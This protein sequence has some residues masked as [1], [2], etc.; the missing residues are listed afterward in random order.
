MG[1]LWPRQWS[2]LIFVTQSGAPIDPS[3]TRKLVQRVAVD[4]GVADEGRGGSTL[5]PYDLRHSATSLL[6]AAGVPPERLADLLGHRDTRM[7]F[8]HY[9]H[10]VTPTI[11]VAVTTW[12]R[13]WAAD[14][15]GQG[16]VREPMREPIGSRSPDSGTPCDD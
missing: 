5:S 16:P 13:P 9:R 7:V 3:N 12:R 11:S 15:P 10:P 2:D 8:K 6:S 1:D 4:A 14:P